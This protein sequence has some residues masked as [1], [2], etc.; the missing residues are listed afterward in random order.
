M[1][2]SVQCKITSCDLNRLIE[3]ELEL[4]KCKH[5]NQIRPH[6]DKLK[7]ALLEQKYTSYLSQTPQTCLCKNFLSGVNFSRMSE[8][9]AFI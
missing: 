9:N 7:Q 5:C 8:K 2:P 4:A 3:V 1:V 6:N